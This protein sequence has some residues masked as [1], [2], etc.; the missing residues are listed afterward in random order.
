MEA[1]AQGSGPH[2]GLQPALHP[3]THEPRRWCPGTAAGAAAA[4]A[5]TVRASV[6]PW[7]VEGWGGSLAVAGPRPRPAAGS[8]GSSEAAPGAGT[9]FSAGTGGNA[10]PPEKCSIYRRPWLRE[11]CQRS[12][13]HGLGP[14]CFSTQAYIWVAKAE[15]DGGSRCWFSHHHLALSSELIFSLGWGSQVVDGGLSVL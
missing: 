8:A 3:R 14:V 4:A 11:N 2:P 15:S 1:T 7:P 5:A 12:K 6:G 13:G 9:W 10:R